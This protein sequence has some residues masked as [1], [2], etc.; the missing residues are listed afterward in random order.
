MLGLEGGA[1]GA[2]NDR[3]ILFVG[4]D[5][6]FGKR[7]VVFTSAVMGAL[8]HGAADRLVSGVTS[9]LASAG[10]FKFV[11]FSLYLS[12]PDLIFAQRNRFRLL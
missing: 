1:V 6:Y 5:L 8:R 3:R 9:T 2:L 7:A 4:Y 11:H 12:F 10:I